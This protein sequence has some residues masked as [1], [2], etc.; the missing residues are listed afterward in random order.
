MPLKL[1]PWMERL[2][3]Q[4]KDTMQVK[5]LDLDDDFAWAQR[6]LVKTVEQTYNAGLPV[7]IIVLKGR[8]L[9]ISTASEGLLF[10]WSFI[11][12]GS[13][14]L[15][16]AHETRAAQH[17]FEMTKLMWEEWWLRGVYTEKHNSQK[18]LGWVET[19][20]GISVAT[21]KNAGSGRSFTYRAVHC[22]ECGFWDD[23]EPLLTGLN[24]S[25]PNVHGTLVIYESTAN[26]VGNWFHEEWS[27]AVDGDSAV[28]PLFF[29]WFL[30]KPYSIPRTTLTM[31]DMKH[32][33]REIIKQFDLSIPQM[34]WR[35]Y[36]I[37]NACM[38]DELQFKQEYP[39]SP[40][41]A[42]I[43]TGTNVFPTQAVDQCYEKRGG[44]RGFLY[45]DNGRIK[46]KRDPTGP[47]TIYHTPADIRKYGNWG[48]Y[49]VVGDPSRTAYGDGACIQVLNRRTFEQ[50]AVYHGHIEPIAFGWEMMRL[51]YF[52]NTA[53]LNV[54]IT[55]PG[56]ASITCI[57]ENNYPEVWRWRWG[58]KAPGKVAL[59]YGWQ[60][61]YNRKHQAAGFLINALAQGYLTIHDPIT[62]RELVNY[63]TLP[64]GEMGPAK[65]SG[66]DDSVT[67]LMIG[68]TTI[69][70]SDPL[71]YGDDESEPMYNDIMGQTME[72]AFRA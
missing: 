28:I 24:Q 27:R 57:L 22:S 68:V 35:R 4:D 34:A 46:F 51:G 42:F 32:E 6:E 36:M 31:R 5:R 23:P 55:G 59:S 37:E 52:Y 2:A 66:N 33:E 60:M 38:G 21:A 44:H 43:V 56:Y 13:Q 47:L 9:G 40:E 29:P 54:E 30:H 53:L 62:Y 17:L 18:S 72:E 49:V 50:V 3:I 26:G 65:P 11:F 45:D 67:S 1:R 71:P 63:V 10:N 19:R 70:W 14:S 7:R 64:N 16:I 39:C 69:R 25:V 41:E 12:P 15:V 8:Q 61:S 20:S 48:K 58:D